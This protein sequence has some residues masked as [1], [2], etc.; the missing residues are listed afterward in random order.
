M[1]VSILSRPIEPRLRVPCCDSSYVPA[2]LLRL[3]IGDQVPNLGD[4][5]VA[6]GHCA[7]AGEG[8]YPGDLV[9]GVLG[10]LHDERGD[11]V[12]DPGLKKNGGGSWDEVS[13]RQVVGVDVGV[14]SLASFEDFLGRGV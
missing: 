11:A 6:V 5:T 13:E 12:L 8:K 10:T 4:D 7:I 2:F 3:F 9:P 14:M 1:S